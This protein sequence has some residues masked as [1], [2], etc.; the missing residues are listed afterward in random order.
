[1]AAK[2]SLNAAARA[3][4][5]RAAAVRSSVLSLLQAFSMGFRSGEYGGRYS[6]VAPAASIASRT[7]LTLWAE[8]LSITTTSPR[9]RLG[10]STC[11][12]KVKNT[13]PSTAASRLTV[14]SG[15]S[16]P[17]TPSTVVTCQ[18]PP[19]TAPSTRCP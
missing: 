17:T 16:H 8:R 6:S 13:A 5:V 9:L 1:M 10:A 18:C 2:A 14:A 15:P 11:R 7:P 3:S 19:G 12:T 4:A